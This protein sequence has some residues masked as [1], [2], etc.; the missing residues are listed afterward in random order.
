MDSNELS[1]KIRMKLNEA[2][3]VY[4]NKLSAI[5]NKNEPQPKSASKGPIN[6]FDI[7]GQKRK[8]ESMD[9]EKSKEY[10]LIFKYREGYINA[11]KRPVPF[12]FFI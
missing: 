9:N 1:Y 12:E 4:G 10:K 6:P 11:V 8:R 5:K 7:L 3:R 2:E